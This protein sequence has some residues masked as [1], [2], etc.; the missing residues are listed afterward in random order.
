MPA[1]SLFYRL[2]IPKGQFV[3]EN[4]ISLPLERSLHIHVDAP[5]DNI[6]LTM[7]CV[8]R[9]PCGKDRG[10]HPQRMIKTNA[11]LER[12]STNIT[13]VNNKPPHRNLVYIFIE[14]IVII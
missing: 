5:A 8:N 12:P 2:V 11:R 10:R 1:L 4:V 9:C 6:L 13:L 3:S 14:S 7:T